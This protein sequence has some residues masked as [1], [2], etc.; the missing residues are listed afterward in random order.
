LT[1]RNM[2]GFDADG[3]ARDWEEAHARSL[4]D[5]LGRPSRHH[6]VRGRSPPPM[7]AAVAVVTLGVTPPNATGAALTCRESPG[8]RRKSRP[9]CSGRR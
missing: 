6:P 5:L 7:E 4:A 9:A 2:F 1:K 8:Y 3:Q